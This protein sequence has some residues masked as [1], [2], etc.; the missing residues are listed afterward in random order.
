M[1]SGA[2]K[3][4]T[5]SFALFSHPYGQAIQIV[6]ALLYKFLWAALQTQAEKTG[7]KGI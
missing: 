4:T 7:R 3:V 1:P 2:D 5:D 6:D